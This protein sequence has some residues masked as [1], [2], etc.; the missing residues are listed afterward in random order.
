MS[1][2]YHAVQASKPQRPSDVAILKDDI[3]ELLEAPTRLAHAKAQLWRRVV[4]AMHALGTDDLTEYL[5]IAG[6]AM[7]GG[8]VCAN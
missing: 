1:K 3:A 8:T 7:D 5:H 4:R 6:D 2:Y